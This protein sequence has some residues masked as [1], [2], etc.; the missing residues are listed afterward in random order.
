M[1]KENPI[2][3]ALAISPKLIGGMVIGYTTYAENSNLQEEA[4][5]TLVKN[6]LKAFEDKYHEKFKQENWSNTA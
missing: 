3:F 5:I 4:I 2:G 1:Q 6:W